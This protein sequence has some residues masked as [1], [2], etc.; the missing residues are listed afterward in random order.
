MRNRVIFGT[1]PRTSERPPIPRPRPTPPTGKAAKAV[2]GGGCG[3]D[4]RHA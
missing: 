3:F 2:W 1:F 4:A